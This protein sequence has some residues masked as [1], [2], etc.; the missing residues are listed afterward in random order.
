MVRH[1]IY[2][3]VMIK[4]KVFYPSCSGARIC[5]IVVP[6]H[7]VLIVD[8][9]VIHQDQRVTGCLTKIE[10]FSGTEVGRAQ[11]AHIGKER[12]R[13]LD[14]HRCISRANMLASDL[15]EQTTIDNNGRACGIS[16]DDATLNIV[17]V[18]IDGLEVSG[19]HD[20]FHYQI[21]ASKLKQ[22]P[23]R[24]VRIRAT[25]RRV[26]HNNWTL[27]PAIIGAKIHCFSGSHI[28]G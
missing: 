8:E 6:N 21:T 3:G 18:C 28:E 22:I 16:I 19:D 13:N 9:S 20:V 2:D 17:E 12:V 27:S 25:S 24:P 14:F 7:S 4:E 23:G 10:A 5:K 11:R 26:Q 15:R 1:A